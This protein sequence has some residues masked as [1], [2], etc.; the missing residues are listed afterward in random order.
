MQHIYGDSLFIKKGNIEVLIDAGWEYDGAFVNDFVLE[1][2]EDKRLDLLMFSHSDGD[3]VDGSL[4]AIKG[5]EDIARNMYKARGLDFDKEFN[6][7]KQL[8]GLK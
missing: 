7:F 5:I 6:A 4:E 8:L 3:H 1:H 2:C